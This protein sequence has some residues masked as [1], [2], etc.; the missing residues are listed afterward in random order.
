MRRGTVSLLLL[1]MVECVAVSDSTWESELCLVTS[2][3]CDCED[4]GVNVVGEVDNEVRGD[5]VR[6]EDEGNEE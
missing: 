2:R 3:G 5:E 6:G 4:R 1:A